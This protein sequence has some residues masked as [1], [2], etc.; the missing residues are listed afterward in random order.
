MTIESW[1][2]SSAVVQ[3]FYKLYQVTAD[4]IY[5]MGLSGSEESQLPE[6]MRDWLGRLRL[7][8][9]VPF[10]Y[11]VPDARLLPQESVRFF[12]LDRNWTDRM[13]DGALSVGKT[14]TREY[15]H[16]HAVNKLV[17]DTLDIEE[18]RMRPKLRFRNPA[19]TFMVGQR[20][21]VTGLL[22]RS[23][24][25][26]G[27][28]GMEISAYSDTN[29][30][31][32]LE[33]LRMDRLSPDVMFC[34]FDGI[35]RA[36]RV[37]EPREGLQFGVE[38]VTPPGSTTITGFEL[39]LR[40]MHGDKAGEEIKTGPGGSTE[41]IDVPVRSSNRRVIHVRELVNRL[42]DTLSGLDSEVDASDRPLLK[43]GQL[44]SA[45]LAVQMSQF[46]YVQIFRGD[47]KRPPASPVFTLESIYSSATFKVGQVISDLSDNEVQALSQ[48][49]KANTSEIAFDSRLFDND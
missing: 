4:S 26:S 2:A 13:V 45:E 43:D 34:L 35:P 28:P 18:R 37:E 12:Y 10:V 30:T 40:Y 42:Q 7:L 24:A 9:G 23:A 21:D 38:L 15:A 46:P 44:R 29:M 19:T 17:V 31:S 25:V 22:M 41:R 5:E 6:S 20:R 49:I 32:R 33:L 3:N 47:G 16:H 27:W 14:T 1:A 36:I 8:Y 39:K 48:Q 11:L